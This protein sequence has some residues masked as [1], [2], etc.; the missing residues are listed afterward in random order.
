MTEVTTPARKNEAAERRRRAQVIALVLI[1]LILLLLAVG[2]SFVIV[3]T[4]IPPG[5]SSTSTSTGSDGLTW[6]R[7]IYG[8]GPAASQQLVD[9][10]D[11]AIDGDGN[12]YTTYAVGK[13]IVVFRPDGSYLRTIGP[14]A[15]GAGSPSPITVPTGVSVDERGE[16]YVSDDEGGRVLVFSSTGKLLRS[17]KVNSARDV[18][19]VGDRVFVSAPGAV[20]IF[21]RQGKL[22]FPVGT[23]GRKKDQFESPVA[24][25]GDDDGTFYVAD[26]LNGRIKAYSKQGDLLWIF[27]KNAETAK[28]AP[29]NLSGSA[30]RDEK[31]KSVLSLPLGVT[32]DAKGRLLVMDAFTFKLSVL[33]PGKR[34]AKL[35][36]QYGTDGAEDGKFMYPSDIAYDEARDW[37]VVADVRNNRLQVFRVEGTGGGNG[38]LGSLKRSNLGPIWV[39][40]LPLLAL[41]LAIILLVISRRLRERRERNQDDAS[42]DEELPE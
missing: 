15:M 14:G 24:L 12:I 18:Q 27:P 38:L 8:W 40:A 9:P 4:V 6:V 28:P 42:L 30:S 1:L 13:S 35:L 37:I 33:E 36:K 19:V 20:G 7:S 23:P 21:D 2:V 26:S 39:C 10:T 3:R 16:V 17:W 34:G 5:G 25:A 22:Q 41:L 11:V 31:G 32:L 29:S